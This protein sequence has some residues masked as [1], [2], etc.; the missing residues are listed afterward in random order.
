MFVAGFDVAHNDTDA[1]V[2]GDGR[3]RIEMFE[4]GDRGGLE[5]YLLD[6]ARMVAIHVARMNPETSRDLGN[7][8]H[9]V[10]SCPFKCAN[11]EKGFNQFTRLCVVPTFF[12]PER[13]WPPPS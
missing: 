12:P 7:L 4:E 13:P 3:L 9:V 2:V 6:H 10:A 1:M 5:R 11:I 8:R